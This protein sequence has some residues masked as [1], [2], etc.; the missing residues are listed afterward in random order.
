MTRMTLLAL[1]LALATTASL[2]ACHRYRGEVD[3]IYVPVQGD[4]GEAYL[5]E[6]PEL[7]RDVA[8][9]QQLQAREEARAAKLHAREMRRQQKIEAR[10]ARRAEKL[11]RREAR[12]AEK[13]RARWDKQQLAL[14]ARHPDGF[15]VEA[16]PMAPSLPAYPYGPPEEAA[17]LQADELAPPAPAAATSPAPPPTSLAFAFGDAVNQQRA[18]RRLPELDADPV[19]DALASRYA[20][21]LAAAELK[22]PDPRGVAAIEAAE[23]ALGGAAHTAFLLDPHGDYDANAVVAWLLDDTARRDVLLA[24]QGATVGVGMAE[25]GGVRVVVV[26]VEEE[27]GT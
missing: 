10:E 11:E 4:D 27:V 21:A 7:T 8:R 2:G 15:I 3:P 12:R 22:Q 24:P 23:D 1:A 19:L 20:Q 16:P 25:V 26:V 14:E 17:E 5:V 13:L 9:A 18:W 6:S